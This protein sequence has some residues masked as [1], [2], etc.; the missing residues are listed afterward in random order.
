M[1]KKIKKSRSTADMVIS[2]AVAAAGI[3][4][5]I[6]KSDTLLTIGALIALAGIVLFLLMKSEYTIE[7]NEGKFHKKMIDLPRNE[8][9]AIL[10]FLDGKADTL[11]KSDAG[12]LLIYIYYKTD[13]TSGFAQL[14]EFEQG[15]YRTD[16]DLVPL[17]ARQVAAALK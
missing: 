17:N 8:R 6:L 2:I 9:E 12:G 11:P 15:E 10:A 5:M 7:G 3:L 14:Y 4:L 1:E 16:T 13:K